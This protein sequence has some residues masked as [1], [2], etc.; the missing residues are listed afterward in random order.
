MT[1]LWGREDQVSR[2]PKPSEAPRASPAFDRTREHGVHGLPVKRS[3]RTLKGLP[4]EPSGARV[5][6]ASSSMTLPNDEGMRCEYFSK[7]R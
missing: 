1:A 4:L 3:A 6:S 5:L 2:F 7:K